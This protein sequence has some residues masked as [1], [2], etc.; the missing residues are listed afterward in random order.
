LREVQDIL[1]RGAQIDVVWPLFL[2]IV[3]A[4]FSV[5]G[6]IFRMSLAMKQ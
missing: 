3:M 1:Y 4:F 2:A 5:V 6:Y